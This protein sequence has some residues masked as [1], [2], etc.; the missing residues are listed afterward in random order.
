M[1]GF[2]TVRCIIKALDSMA[3]SSYVNKVATKLPPPCGPDG[4]LDERKTAAL[5][6]AAKYLGFVGNNAPSA[7]FL[8]VTEVP[9]FLVAAAGVHEGAWGGHVAVRN[10]ILRQLPNSM[11]AWKWGAPSNNTNL[12]TRSP[13][14]TGAISRLPPVAA[15]HTRFGSSSG[16]ESTESSSEE[17][18]EAEEESADPF[19]VPSK[20][21]SD[22]DASS[23]PGSE[24]SS[25]DDRE[26]IMG[27]DEGESADDLDIEYEE[28][29]YG[30]D[31][32]AGE[33]GADGQGEDEDDE[34]SDDESESEAE[35]TGEGEE[36]DGA[37]PKAS[38]EDWHDAGSEFGAGEE[39]DRAGAESTDS[40][41]PRPGGRLERYL[42]EHEPDKLYVPSD[43]SK[44]DTDSE[45]VVASIDGITP[46]YK[47]VSAR[48]TTRGN[49]SEQSD[50]EGSVCKSDGSGNSMEEDAHAT[51]S[52]MPWD[53]EI[54]EDGAAAGGIGAMPLPKA[55][56]SKKPSRER[57]G[58]T[59][60]DLASKTQ[61][62]VMHKQLELIY[63][64]AKSDLNA[65]REGAAA[66]QHTIGKIKLAMGLFSGFVLK[67]K[68][69]STRVRLE[70]LFNGPLL[71]DWIEFCVYDR[72]VACNTL[73]GY[74]VSVNQVLNV[75]R[76]MRP[77]LAGT[78]TPAVEALCKSL[79]NVRKQLT[80][81][82]AVAKGHKMMVT[83]KRTLDVLKSG[84]KVQLAGIVGTL[85]YALA[86]EYASIL[87][88]DLLNVY[89]TVKP[90]DWTKY[91]GNAPDASDKKS[92]RRRHDLMT[93]S[94]AL[95][96]AWW[97][98]I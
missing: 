78:G 12:D 67:S 62:A 57:Y 89:D 71:R 93:L 68:G 44:V 26:S 32:D 81:K 46:K 22:S 41:A 61:F 30:S 31:G 85:R 38:S 27:E 91:A 24:S 49:N 63:G 29:A 96:A 47:G 33:G 72:G 58:V 48:G 88:Q 18:A 17:D 3:S 9:D 42:R 98:L 70:M 28:P 75:L 69:A 65:E 52:N 2:V 84:D 50:M 37:T 6:A 15:V 19:D 55:G 51:G 4:A 74:L 60:K 97:R 40:R 86:V 8:H 35:G 16:D 20:S 92:L 64:F 83:T 5:L 76:S 39:C 43:Q 45:S 80:G 25:D 66:K 21:G 82:S 53:P 10:A 54:V 11:W 95:L 23:Q 73:T 36:A 1:N 87:A 7:T 77:Q 90:K 56:R 13:A 34:E 14:A 59:P 94:R 79:T